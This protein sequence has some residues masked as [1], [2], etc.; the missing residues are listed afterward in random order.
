MVKINRVFKGFNRDIFS[1]LKKIMHACHANNNEIIIFYFVMTLTAMSLC[2]LLMSAC[3]LLF[4]FD[5][6]FIS[7]MT[8][9]TIYFY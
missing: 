7:R 1:V 6:D 9:N 4:D 3:M 8:I 5:F 2:A